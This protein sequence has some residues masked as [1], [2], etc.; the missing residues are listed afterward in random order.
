[1]QKLLLIAAAFGVSAAPAVAQTTAAPSQPAAPQA[2]PAQPKTTT[3]LVCREVEEE[4][5]IG[6]R[7]AST[8]KICRKVVVPAPANGQQ[9]P[10]Q[11]SRDGSR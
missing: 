4:R 3:K 5:S 9:Q 11:P 2:A 10:Q 8:T 1:M 6:S 7:L